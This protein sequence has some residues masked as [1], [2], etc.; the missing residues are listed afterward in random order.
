M[1][2]SIDALANETYEAI[3]SSP[4]ARDQVFETMYESEYWGAIPDDETQAEAHRNQAWDDY[5]T[6]IRVRDTAEDFV[7]DAA[8]HYNAM[9]SNQNSFA[10]AAGVAAAGIALMIGA[11]T[12]SIPKDSKRAVGNYIALPT[13]LAGVLMAVYGARRRAR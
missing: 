11:H 1:T 8:P 2:D 13:A 10:K 4:E 5:T 7:R 9:R 3:S 12:F 6:T